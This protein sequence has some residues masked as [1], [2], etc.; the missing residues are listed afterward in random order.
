MAR[1]S[2]QKLKP[3]YI[4][5]YLLQDTDEDH[6]VTV[7]QIISYLESQG[8]SAER[9]SIYSDIEALQCFGLDIV[10]AGSGR[11]CGYYVAHR[12]FELPELKLLVDSVQSSKF[13]THKKT[14]TLIKKIETLASIHEAQLLNR[15][16]FVKNRIKTMN[17]SIYYN[18][19][20]IHNGISKN[21][22]IRFLYFEYNVQKE[23]QYRRNGA[24]YVV[25][26][27]ALTW[28]DENYYMVA[29]DSDAAIIK[30]YRVDKMEKISI[31]EEDRDG[32]EAYQALDMAIYARKTFGMFTGKEEHVVLRFENHLVGAVL[33]RLGRDVFIVPDGPDHFTVR[34]DV[35]V[36][37]Q[38]FAWVTGFGTS[39]QVIGPGHVVEAMKDHICAVAGQYGQ[40]PE[41]QR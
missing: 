25:S 40:R 26:P 33:D 4:M 41:P 31:L 11:S 38:F 20:E 28:D 18:V 27:F 12:N 24:Y 14:A 8:I 36:S 23:R 21:K 35:I 22:K 13:I 17:E 32:L 10:Q 15:Q 37:P 3:L 9:K 39:A 2:Y 19:D 34:T 29:Y 30:N 1:S 16:V 6:P 5:N 7:N